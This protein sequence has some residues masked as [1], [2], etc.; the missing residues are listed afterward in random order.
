MMD[1]SRLLYLC[2]CSC[3]L[4][5]F[6]LSFLIFDAVTWKECPAGIFL[7][8][9]SFPRYNRWPFGNPIE[10]ACFAQCSACVP[11]RLVR[12]QLCIV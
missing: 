9:G 2:K 11:S 4:F 3:A 8:T 12:L 1:V 5:S 6:S 7:Q 10:K